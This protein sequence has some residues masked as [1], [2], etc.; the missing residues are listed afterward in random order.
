MGDSEARK[1]GV[2]FEA[3]PQRVDEALAPPLADGP[4]V[5]LEGGKSGP[6]V[7][8]QGFTVYDSL[9]LGLVVVWAGNPAFIKWALQ[10]LDP[11]VFNA[12]RFALATLVLLVWV[13]L[14]GEGLRWHK[15]DGLKLFALGLVGHGVYQAL[16]ILSI[17]LTLAGN[18]ALILSI[19]PV[20]VA[21]FSFL[22]GYERARS[23]VWFGVSLTMLGA[24]LVTF[25]TGERLEL[26][27]RLLGDLLILVATVM[28]GL[29]TVVSQSFLTRYSSY[30]LNALTMP[31]G[32]FFLLV[33]AAPAFVGTAH[34]F[35][36]VSV[37]AWGVLVGSG[38]LAVA[39]SYV[40]WY[41]GVQK[42]GATR[43][44][45][46]SNLV[47]VLA[48]FFSFFLLR[49]PLGWQ[50]WAGMALVLGGVTLARF[51]GRLMPRP[52]TSRT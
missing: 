14:R 6:T 2:P 22:L 29:Y 39:A 20:F 45:I 4:T 40:V 35:P 51:G 7:P 8:L 17:N 15:G 9:L 28:W 43:T 34:T 27:S 41:Q 30:K 13:L 19:N 10:D 11:L 42:L 36:T 38:L 16:F 44:A 18:V 25:G 26:G 5:D 32:S 12:L 50:F 52:Q 1:A 21:V 33:V 47:P 23:Y 24:A 48:A 31:I 49:E 37:G 3:K 46:Y